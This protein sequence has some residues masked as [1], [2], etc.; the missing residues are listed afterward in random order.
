[1][2]GLLISPATAG[3][4]VK[5]IKSYEKAVHDERHAIERTAI[6]TINQPTAQMAPRNGLAEHPHG[7]LTSPHGAITFKKILFQLQS[8]DGVYCRRA[9]TDDHNVAQP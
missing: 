9:R 1:M 3:G 7:P 6:I 8:H 5:K 2:E 4:N